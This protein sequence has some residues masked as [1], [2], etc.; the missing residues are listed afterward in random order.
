[1][2]LEIAVVFDVL[3]Q[4]VVYVPVVFRASGIA[5][6]FMVGWALNVRGFE[7]YN[8][9]F[10][11]VLNLRKTDSHA[12]HV[13]EATKLLACALFFCY[14]LHELC[15]RYSFETGQ[16]ISLVAFWVILIGLVAVSKHSIF[17]EMR[18]FVRARCVAFFK[19]EVFFVDVLAADV[20]CSMSKLLADM[21]VV[22]CAIFALFTAYPDASSAACAHSMVGPTLASLPFAIRAVQCLVA[23]NAT[24]LYAHL[25]NFGKYISSFPVI[26]ISALQHQWAPAEGV[27]LDSH[28][29]YL[30]ELWLYSVTINTLYSF[31]WDVLMDWGLALGGS[32]LPLLRDELL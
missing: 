7:A 18:H 15:G 2:M 8:I 14:L 12:D 16:S 17:R 27:V 23:Y 9:P 6:L 19:G 32:R 4:M 20:L 26:W 22:V 5:V 29:Q 11:K 10:R 28:D 30:Q 1:M 25:L 3:T 24:G 13:M 21:Q 31:V